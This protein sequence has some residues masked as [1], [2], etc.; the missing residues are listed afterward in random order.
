MIKQLIREAQHQALCA[1]G[2]AYADQAKY[3]NIYWL[4]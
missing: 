2:Q 3:S 4:A 1:L